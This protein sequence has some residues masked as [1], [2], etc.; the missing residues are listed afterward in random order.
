MVSSGADTNSKM[1][2]G[3][4][5][6]YGNKNYGDE[7]IIAAVIQNIRKIK[8]DANLY[9]FSINP[10]D[11]A[12]RY[13]VPAY[14]IRSI[15]NSGANEER[16]KTVAKINADDSGHN[17][18]DV[19]TKTHFAIRFMKNIPF[20]NWVGRNILQTVRCIPEIFSELKFM[21]KSYKIVKEI[22]LLIITG[23]NQFLDNFGGV[24][25]F[26][27]T[28]L[29]WSVLAK[30]S[31]TKL[32]F[33][34]VGAGPLDGMM[35]KVFVRV[36]I[37]FS[38]Y[39]S[40]RDLASRSLIESGKFN[41]NGLVCPDLAFSFMRPNHTTSNGSK[42]EAGQKPTIGINPMPMY[43]DRYWCEPDDEKYRNYIKKLAV[44]T[45]GLIKQEYPV[46]FTNTMSK[47]ENVIN[48]VIDLLRKDNVLTEDSQTL[49]RINQSVDELIEALNSADIMI[50]TR[51]HGVVLS[52]LVNK[53]LIAICYY[54]KSKFLMED[55]GQGKYALD[56]EN[57]EIEELT[58]CL[59][60]LESNYS[61]RKDEI[62]HKSIEYRAQLEQQ[63]KK[64]LTLL[65]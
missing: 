63:Y 45:S 6:H 44:F 43:D 33:A 7:A 47:D 38:D 61:V 12:N 20:V 17:N 22:D 4:F 65:D 1:N 23:S 62:G 64:I 53:P 3:I 56:F 42:V 9:C 28:L 30:L 54:H 31:E 27:F 52:L 35:S 25:G 15:E 5:G 48:D 55:M 40:Y 58:S 51:F 37:L 34:S 26:P 32:A 18:S 19:T 24:W 16:Q 39:L 49:V 2:I 11:S 36:A 50:A 59:T 57:F 29:K 21:V 60:D 14:P 41:P 10:D 8:P 46:F 13:H